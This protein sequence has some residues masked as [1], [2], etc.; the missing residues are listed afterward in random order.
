MCLQVP[1]LDQEKAEHFMIE[2]LELSKSCLWL[3]PPLSVSGVTG[4]VCGWL[5]A[6]TGGYL[7]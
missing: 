6:F 3:L 2:S 5:G 1:G 7:A 4:D